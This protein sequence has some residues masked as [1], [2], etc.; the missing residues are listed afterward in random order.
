M[1]GADS[2]SSSTGGTCWVD[3]ASGCGV[4][5]SNDASY[6]S[7][8]AR[9]RDATYSFSTLVASPS[10][11]AVSANDSPLSVSGP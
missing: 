10:T 5:S 6:A 2:N 7:C 8:S 3:G 1:Y 4:W 11:R 9:G